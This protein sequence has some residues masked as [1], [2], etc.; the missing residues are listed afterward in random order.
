M[1]AIRTR[2]LF[3]SRRSVPLASL[4]PSN[5]GLTRCYAHRSTPPRPPPEQ[6][7]YFYY[8]DIHGRLFLHD[9]W[10]RNI[11]SCFKDRRFLNFFFQR[12]RPNTT[13]QHEGQYPYISLCGKEVNY[14]EPADTPVVYTDLVNE[15]KQLVWGG[16]LLMPFNPANLHVHPVSGYVYHPSPDPALGKLAL[17]SS[18]TILRYI[19]PT[20]DIDKVEYQWKGTTYPVKL[21]ELPSD[22][23][24][25]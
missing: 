12:L 20:L 23:D 17:V 24:G 11:T 21:I 1:H 9:V 6:R 25:P 10:P 2:I 7:T 5:L 3:P 16:A 14:L 4:V 13:G 19:S 8:L 18:S 15:G 22:Q